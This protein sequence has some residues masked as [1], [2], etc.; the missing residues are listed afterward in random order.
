MEKAFFL[1][2]FSLPCSIITDAKQRYK[3]CHDGQQDE[4]VPINGKII[5]HDVDDVKAAQRSSNHFKDG[6]KRLKAGKDRNGIRY[7]PHV[8]LV[9]LF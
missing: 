2:Q 4:D 5:I 6:G 7:E 1:G 3:G 9:H 8:V